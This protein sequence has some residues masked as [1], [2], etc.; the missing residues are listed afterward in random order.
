MDQLSMIS[1][2]KLFS[3]ISAKIQAVRELLVTAVLASKHGQ[4]SLY[5]LLKL[6]KQNLLHSFTRT[7]VTVGAIASGSAA[8]VVLVGF[9]Y[10]LEAIV[11]NRLVLP[12]SLRLADIQ[13][14]S[15][16][17]KLTKESLQQLASL[18][19]VESVAEAVS[20]AGTAK[21]DDSQTEVVVTGARNQFLDFAHV[22]LVAGTTFSEEAEVAYDGEVP[23]LQELAAQAEGE[24]A[25]VSTE[26]VPIDGD[27]VTDTSDRFRVVDGAYVPLRSSPNLQ[28]EIIGYVRGSVLDS[29]KAYR[30][31]GQA[32]E[33]D[34][35]A[36][37]KYQLFT[38]DWKGEWLSVDDIPVYQ[39]TAPSVYVPRTDEAGVEQKMSGYLTE[40]SVLLLSSNEAMAEKALQQLSSG[41]VLG[42]STESAS[43]TGASD[44]TASTVSAN[45]VS[46]VLDN[47]ATN[48]ATEQNLLESIIAESQ[49]NTATQSSAL[50]IANVEKTGGKELLVST[51][52]LSPLKLEP[53]DVIGKEIQLQYIVGAGLVPG[54][55]GRVLAQAVTYKIV[56]VFENK[57][58]SMVFVPL[59]D[60]E[61]MGVAKYSIA[62]VLA[63]NETILPQVRERIGALGFMT[64]S[65]ADTLAQVNKLFSVMRFLLG[66]FGMI[67]F[68][69]ALFGMFN[70]L[71]VSLLERTREIGVMKTFGT[72]DADITRLLIVESSLIGISGGIFGILLG[73]LLGNGLNLLSLLVRDDK[74]TSLFHFP[75]FFLFLVFLLAGV[76][77]MMTGLYPAR[78]AQSIS[79]LNALRY[80]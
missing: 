60:L 61:S 65:I 44:E 62:K 53:Q 17:H 52:F 3:F 50:A 69:V 56:G 8:I 42:D 28:S 34:G 4:L 30:V 45:L 40:K 24:V 35:T 73:V 66:S 2:T 23:N 55:N 5:Y 15:T 51:G 41:L 19:G 22:Q 10:G 7:A 27:R 9:A 38:G 11:T 43:V 68:I 75:I 48:S 29:Y 36:G 1:M 25:G 47:T 37:K 57:D 58:Q 20:L 16:A 64:R 21:Y 79:A 18:E 71:T 54:I 76:I 31:W 72:T 26:F 12:N 14:S 77:G 80:E 46:V 78:R 74:A 67:A 13:S 59:S 6:G 49:G 63:K 70:T 39:E 33:S 32:Y